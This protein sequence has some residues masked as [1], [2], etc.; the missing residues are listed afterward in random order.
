ML[1]RSEGKIKPTRRTRLH[2]STPLE[3]ISTYNAEIRGICNYYSLASNFNTLNY[4]SYLMEYSCLKT[5][6]GKHKSKISKIKEKYKDGKGKWGIPYETKRGFMR[7]YIAKL[8]DCRNSNEFNDII[9][10]A[11]TMYR[12][13]RNSFESRLIANECELC[14]TTNAKQYEIHHVNKVKT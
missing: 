13:S 11:E 10:N 9:G 14:G 2:G 7:S 8:S 3:I 5:L 4:F 6:A 1:F 12:L